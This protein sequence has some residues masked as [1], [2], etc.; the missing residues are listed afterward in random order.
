MEINENGFGNRLLQCMESTGITN[1]EI[2]KQL[3]LSKNAIGNYKNNQIP[4]ASIL[5]RLSQILGVTME[6]LLTGENISDN[7]LTPDEKKLISNYKIS[8]ESG[9]QAIMN[10]AKTFADQATKE[11]E[12]SASKIG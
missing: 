1:A 9:K 3:N 10:V 4:N 8:S 12:L 6:W 7:S 5:F 2:T 11:G